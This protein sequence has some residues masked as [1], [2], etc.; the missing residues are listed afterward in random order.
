[1]YGHGL[2]LVSG[3]SMVKVGDQTPR[4]ST[5]N[6]ENVAAKGLG[7]VALG[8]LGSKLNVF[9]SASLID[10]SVLRGSRTSELTLGG[11][12]GIHPTQGG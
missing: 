10:F 3:R 8:T 4:Q 11:M 12:G 9:S 5:P 6:R 7:G 1:M 2:L